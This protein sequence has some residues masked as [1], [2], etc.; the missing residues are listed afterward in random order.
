MLGFLGDYYPRFP[1]GG[2]AV[3]FLAVMD[4]AMPKRLRSYRIGIAQRC[5]IAFIHCRLG[6]SSLHSRTAARWLASRARQA[7]HHSCL[8][9]HHPSVCMDGGRPRLA[10]LL[11]VTQ[12]SAR[13]G[14]HRDPIKSSHDLIEPMAFILAVRVSEGASDTHMPSGK[15]SRQRSRNLLKRF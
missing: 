7:Q 12:G 4:P 10:S 3:K 11:G 8:H 1:M 9:R 14:P 5:L 15:M 2:G 6:S 13:P